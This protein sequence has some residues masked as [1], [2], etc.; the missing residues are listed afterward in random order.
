M[1]V[2]IEMLASAGPLG[3]FA[4]YL[5]WSHNKQEKKMDELQQQWFSRL[6][7]IE[8]NA[9]EERE[10]I[11]DKFE[12][13]ADKSRERWVGVVEKVEGERDEV[14]KDLGQKIDQAT[15]GLNSVHLKLEELSGKVALL[16]EKVSE[17][18]SSKK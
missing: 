15:Q 11:E 18:C 7:E 12:T 17:L 3:I 1:E 16:N 9:K 5:I 4:A 6:S 10:S 2:F 13:R 14:Q 8:T